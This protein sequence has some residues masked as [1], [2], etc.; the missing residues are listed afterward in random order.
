MRALIVFAR[1][2]I[3][4]ETKTRLCPPL[5]AAT[6]AALYAAF[7]QDALNL[8][9]RVPGV[10]PLIDYSPATAGPFF[11]R[12]APDLPARPQQGEDLGPRMDHSLCAALR[13]EGLPAPCAHAVL[14]GSDLPNLPL[15]FVA[16][17][18]ARLDA[19]ADLVLGPAEDG[20]YYLIGLRAPQPRLLHEV[21]MSTP[22]VLADT[23]QIAAELGLR[24]AL[25]PRWYDIDTF[26]D[27]RRLASEPG[28]AAHTRAF[29]ARHALLVAHKGQGA[30][31]QLAPAD[32]PRR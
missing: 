24:T 11:A 14:I 30:A 4:G 12:F 2:P 25:L 9:R 7:L 32:V 13:G 22:T 3:P 21:P 15:A 16:E 27:L 17:A 5:E 23:L 20:G 10:Q 18:F 6:A 28:E 29:L 1:Q 19:G 8:A 26:A 31:S